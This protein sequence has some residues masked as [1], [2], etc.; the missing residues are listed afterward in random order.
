MSNNKFDFNE[1]IIDVVE[2][3]RLAD[4]LDEGIINRLYESLDK[5]SAFYESEEFIP[6]LLAYDLLVLHDNLEG[7]LGVYSG[8]DKIKISNI[9]TRINEYIEKIFL[10]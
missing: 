5:A 7:A 8:D 1:V 3:I 2:K 9:N 4:E 6:K 10:N